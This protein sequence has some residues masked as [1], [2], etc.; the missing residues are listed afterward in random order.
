MALRQRHWLAWTVTGGL[1]RQAWWHGES[2]LGAGEIAMA[3]RQKRGGFHTQFLCQNQLLIVC[4]TYD[5]L[6][7]T[8]GPKVFTDNQMSQIKYNYY[9]NNVSKDYDDS[10]AKRNIGRLHNSTGMATETTR[11]LKL[12]VEEFKSIFSF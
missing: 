3:R 2:E 5:Q 9:I 1:G 11:S 8:Y 4:M 7:H 6:F 12:I 10:Q